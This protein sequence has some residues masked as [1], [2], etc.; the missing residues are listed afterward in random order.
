MTSS[1]PQHAAKADKKQPRT[2]LMRD[3]QMAT[4]G[5]RALNERVA[6]N[7][8]LTHKGTKRLA[9]KLPKITA[10]EGKNG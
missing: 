6:R 8:A 7:K 9:A 3:G 10:D 5:L 4:S 1:L 2:G